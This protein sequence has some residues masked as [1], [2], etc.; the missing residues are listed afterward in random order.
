MN[1]LTLAPN[2]PGAQ[3]GKPVGQTI[4]GPSPPCPVSH[5]PQLTEAAAEL[6]ASLRSKLRATCQRDF[7]I[8][9]KKC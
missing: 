7:K 3:P 6:S 5:G 4:G 9:R 2:K 1:D 8:R